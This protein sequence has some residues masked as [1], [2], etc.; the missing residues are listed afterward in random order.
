[1]KTMHPICTSFTVD[2]VN[3]VADWFETF[4]SKSR[5]TQT[6][7][8]HEVLNVPQSYCNQMMKGRR[9]IPQA[10]IVEICQYFGVSAAEYKKVIRKCPRYK[11]LLNQDLLSAVQLLAWH[12]E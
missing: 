3:H 1:M 12:K 2:E 6:K 11:Q 5:T 7:F 4:M 10:H 9:S 8:A